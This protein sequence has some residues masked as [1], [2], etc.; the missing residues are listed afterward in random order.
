MEKVFD[1]QNVEIRENALDINYSRELREIDR[2]LM[3]W[4]TGMKNARSLADHDDYAMSSNSLKRKRISMAFKAAQSFENPAYRQKYYF[5]CLD[6]GLDYYGAHNPG[7][8]FKLMHPKVSNML[9]SACSGYIKA[10]M[11]IV[12]GNANNDE[13]K[14]IL[15]RNIV[16]FEKLEK[17]LALFPFKRI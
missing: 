9:M 5:E 2:T 17:S 3:E 11:E 4:E 7:L 8:A 6:W 14:L 16:Y 15:M 1:K 13:D 10:A 12:D